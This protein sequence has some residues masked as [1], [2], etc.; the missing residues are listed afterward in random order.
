M[1]KKQ[2]KLI[3]ALIVSSIFSLISYFLL[4]V[5]SQQKLMPSLVRMGIRLTKTSWYCFIALLVALSTLVAIII[6]LKAI[7]KQKGIILKAILCSLLSGITYYVIFYA[8]PRFIQPRYDFVLI[9]I[10]FVFV[11][12]YYFLFFGLKTPK[13]SEPIQTFAPAVNTQQAQ[14]TYT[15]QNISIDDKDSLTNTLLNALKPQLKAPMTAT[16]CSYEEL[17]ITNNNGVYNIEGYVNSQNSYGAMI[18]TDF[19]AQARYVNGMWVISSTTIGVK[20][21]KQYA[22]TFTANYIVI[23]I[24]VGV[25]G[26]LGY[27]I[28]TLIIG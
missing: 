24:F 14:T 7:K 8:V 22:K 12:V 1:E 21:A 17:S 5:L 20:N 2:N 15:P 25:M 9:L 23:S 3:Q 16:L 27:L 4:S 19:T 26:L 10:R 18:A 11:F 6:Y 28:L 13:T